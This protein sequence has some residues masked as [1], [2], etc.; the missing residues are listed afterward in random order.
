MIA[1]LK[2]LPIGV[3]LGLA[4]A[5]FALITGGAATAYLTIYNRGYAAAVEAIAKRDKVAIDAVRKATTE[6]RSCYAGGGTWD[7]T[8]GVCE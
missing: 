1:A 8:R 7:A 2:L 5:V 6:V 3:Q 4:A